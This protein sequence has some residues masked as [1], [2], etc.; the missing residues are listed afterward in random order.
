MELTS[1]TYGNHCGHVPESPRLYTRPAYKK[2]TYDI[3]TDAQDNLKSY[4]FEPKKWLTN[5]DETR[6]RVT[7]GDRMGQQRTESR[8]AVA[9]IAGVILDHLDL[10]TM[11]VV[12]YKKG[13]P[14]DMSIYDIAEKAN[15][16][17]ERCWR[18]LMVLQ[19]SSYVTS[20]QE[21]VNVVALKRVSLQ[22]LH[23]LGISGLRVHLCR[24]KKHKALEMQRGEAAID[25]MPQLKKVMNDL[26]HTITQQHLTDSEIA[27]NKEKQAI[28]RQRKK[29]CDMQFEIMRDLK[30]KHGVRIDVANKQATRTL[31]ERGITYPG[32]TLEELI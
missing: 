29:F 16:T 18:A 31:Y 5:I 21:K 3:L 27:E 1:Y 11:N 22:L 10:D 8:E 15:L 28:E 30:E 32:K 20:Q 26:K 24:G 13:K 19:N 25:K 12:K 6:F 14:R 7:T 2:K 4:Y 17:Y 23:H 9:A